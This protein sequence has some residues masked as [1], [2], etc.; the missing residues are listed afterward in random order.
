MQQFSIWLAELPM[1][2]DSSIIC[3]L[4][5]VIVLSN[6]IANRHSPI[7]TAVPLTSKLKRWDLMTHVPIRG[8]GLERDSMALCEQ[9]MTLDRS[10][11]QRQIGF[12]NNT[13]DRQAL[14]RGVGAQLGLT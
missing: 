8:S 9:I 4:H 14:I 7:I 1:L 11:L 5:P 2:K 12:V 10:V 6:D 13:Q 3:G